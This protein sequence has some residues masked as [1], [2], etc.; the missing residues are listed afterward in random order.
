MGSY[1][2]LKYPSLNIDMPGAASVRLFGT[3]NHERNERV[4]LGNQIRECIVIDDVHIV[5]PPSVADTPVL[6]R[7]VHAMYLRPG[8]VAA[9]S[10]PKVVPLYKRGNPTRFYTR[11]GPE[12]IVIHLLRHGEV[13]SPAP[14]AKA[15]TAVVDQLLALPFSWDP[16]QGH[17]SPA[18]TVVGGSQEC[19]LSV[20][21]TPT[22]SDDDFHSALD[23][24]ARTS[25]KA[26]RW[27]A[28]TSA[29]HDEI[30]SHW[31][32]HLRFLS[33]E[34]YLAEVGAAQVALETQREL[35][36]P[37]PVYIS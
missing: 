10:K 11:M 18:V 15:S 16:S 6:D 27:L 8:D 7:L 4:T 21:L 13:L 22:A 12:K 29:P 37:P 31:R 20:G 2:L 33:P 17:P 19:R 34:Q 5:V 1:F 28:A 35:A 32:A 9:R 36:G 14:V 25:S 24:M 3:P 23:Q 26:N 30:Y